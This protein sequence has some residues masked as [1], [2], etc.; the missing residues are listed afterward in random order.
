MCFVLSGELVVAAGDEIHLLRAGDSIHYDALL[1][2]SWC[3]QG[4]QTCEVIWSQAHY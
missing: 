1:P 3:S 4:E 2:H